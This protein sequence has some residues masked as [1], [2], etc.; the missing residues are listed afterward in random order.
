MK[1]EPPLHSVVLDRAGSAWQRLPSGWAMCGADGSW[2]YT[3]EQVLA[4]S[5]LPFD[6]FLNLARKKVK[7]LWSPK[8]EKR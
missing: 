1:K 5:P 4:E 2:F 7:L 8:K 3:W 6:T